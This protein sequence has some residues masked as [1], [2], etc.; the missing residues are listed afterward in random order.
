MTDADCRKLL[1]E[2]RDA[3]DGDAP[4]GCEH[5]ER[6]SWAFDQGHINRLEFD[7]LMEFVADDAAPKFHLTNEPPK[8]KPW[9]PENVKATQRVLLAGMDCLSGQGN[10]FETDGERRP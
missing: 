1:D 2:L 7:E 8:P 6:L 3:Y 4:E 9:R 5:H 10:L